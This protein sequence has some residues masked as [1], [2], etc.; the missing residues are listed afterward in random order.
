MQPIYTC[1]LAAW[2]LWQADVDK[3]FNEWDRGGDGSLEYKE[4]KKILSA[5]PEKKKEVQNAVVAAQAGLAMMKLV[6]K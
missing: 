3:L 5:V 2:F 6:K 1:A 4:L